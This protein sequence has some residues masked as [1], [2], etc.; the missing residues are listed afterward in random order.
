MTALTRY[1]FDMKKRHPWLFLIDNPK[2]FWGM[3]GV[4]RTL[5]FMVKDTLRF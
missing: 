2:R 3:F 5:V 1:S 4:K